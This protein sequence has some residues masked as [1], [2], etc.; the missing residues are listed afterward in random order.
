MHRRAKTRSTVRPSLLGAI[1]FRDVVNSLREDSGARTLAVFGALGNEPHTHATFVGQEGEIHDRMAGG[2]PRASSHSGALRLV[3]AAAAVAADDDDDVSRPPLAETDGKGHG[4]RTTWS[5]AELASTAGSDESRPGWGETDEED[6]DERAATREEPL[7]D[8]SQGVENP[9]QSSNGRSAGH[10]RDGSRHSLQLD[11]PTYQ[12]R[13]SSKQSRSRPSS[14][15]QRTGSGVSV[16]VDGKKIRRVPSIMLTSATGDEEIVQESATIPDPPESVPFRHRRGYRIARAVFIALFPSLQDFWSKSIVGKATA[17]LCVPAILLLNLTLPVVD[18]E[19]DECASME[20]K[21]ARE[22]AE[23]GDGGYRD[24]YSNDEEIDDLDRPFDPHGGLL[25]A[26]DDMDTPRDSSHQYSPHE[27]RARRELAAK[28]LHNR[29]L[30]HNSASAIS[31][32]EIPSPWTSTTPVHTP[33][34]A[35]GLRDTF[36][37]F[38][39]PA[40]PEAVARARSVIAKDDAPVKPVKGSLSL[41]AAIA[42]ASLEVH[43]DVLTR[44]LTA[45]QCTLGPVFCVCALLSELRELDDRRR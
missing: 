40:G 2:R 35:E 16:D 1:E 39:F 27:A 22:A 33:S 4:R 17:L 14:T 25:I 26:T 8:L 11:I 44:W 42:A 21:E 5:A 9:W 10:S 41:D 29:V 24:E 37:N 12:Y 30:P 36:A 45:I 43:G 3:E 32:A 20:E 18:S 19:Q 28:A 23:A 6:D 34:I 7:I 31:G 15:L 13:A 38:T